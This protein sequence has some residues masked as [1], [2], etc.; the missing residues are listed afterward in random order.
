MPEVSG[1]GALGGALTGATIGGLAGGPFGAL[2]GGGIGL[3]YGL[4]SPLWEPEIKAT[5]PTAMQ[6]RRL[7]SQRAYRSEFGLAADEAREAARS[8]AAERAASAYGRAG[9]LPAGGAVAALL[10]QEDVRGA[11][12]A[13]I[14]GMQVA[15]AKEAASEG[16]MLE[17]KDMELEALRARLEAAGYSPEEINQ[18][19]L[20]QA[21]AHPGLRAAASEKALRSERGGLG[22]WTENL[23]GFFVNT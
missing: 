6:K 3:A 2:A 1:E 8:G 4:L 16:K 14:T 9:E 19:L 5:P 10:A 12:E 18:V 23:G 21:G 7:A 15:E 13:A 11:R 22:G 20:S 17:K